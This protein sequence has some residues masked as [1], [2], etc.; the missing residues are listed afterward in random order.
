[1]EILKVSEQEIQENTNLQQT[2]TKEQVK[3]LTMGR[4]WTKNERLKYLAYRK[5]EQNDL[6]R[7]WK[8]YTE[9]K[10]HSKYKQS[11]SKVQAK[12]K[13]SRGRIILWD[14]ITTNT[15]HLN[16]RSRWWSN[17]R[18]NLKESN[19]KEHQDKH[20]YLWNKLLHEQVK[21]VIW[22]NFSVM[23]EETRNTVVKAINHILEYFIKKWKF[24]NPKTFKNP[25]F[26]PKT[27]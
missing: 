3:L 8:G 19:I 6:K 23:H 14:S 21:Q 10:V 13:K 22:D 7:K 12:P 2:E 20:R 1:M 11:T 25:H 27:I 9:R 18:N 4:E 16:P 17:H 26:I 15:E 5:Q 24:Y